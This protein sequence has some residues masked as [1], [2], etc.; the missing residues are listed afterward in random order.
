MI[1]GRRWDKIQEQVD[2]LDSH[3]ECA[4]CCHRVKILNE[5]SSAEFDV[6]SPRAAGSYTIE[7]LLKGNF[8]MN[9]SAVMRRDPTNA[10]PPRLSEMIV[11]TGRA[12]RGWQEA[13]QSSLATKSWLPI[14]CTREVCGH[15][16][17]FRLACEN[18]QEC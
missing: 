12:P 3:P 7:N 9:C 4:L 16:S 2:Y 15:R 13:E 1:I 14:A 8:V 6:F 18:Q 5:T 10:Y 11:V 17:L